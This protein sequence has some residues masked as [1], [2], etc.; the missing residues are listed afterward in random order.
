MTT[1]YSQ[2]MNYAVDDIR[3]VPAAQ[4]PLACAEPQAE[5]PYFL[6]TNSAETKYFNVLNPQNNVTY[7]WKVYNLN[8]TLRMSGTGASWGVRGSQFV[9]GTYLFRVTA[10]Y[11]WGCTSGYLEIEYD[12]IYCDEG[13]RTAST[14][15][16]YPN[17]ATDELILPQDATDATLVNSK[18]KSLL[19]QSSGQSRLD[20][21]N[22]PDG[23]YELRWKQ[24]DAAKSQR[25]QIK[26]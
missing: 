26:H 11:P 19:Q 20:V 16:A 7:N 2:D 6:C 5:G 22:L 10:T 13:A 17:P 1:P 4:E 12:I 21:R 3:L 23:L 14:L 9:A 15:S 24:K 25:I 18:G 8:G